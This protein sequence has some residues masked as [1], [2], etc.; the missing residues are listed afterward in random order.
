MKYRSVDVHD[1]IEN[2]QVTNMKNIAGDGSRV[3]LVQTKCDVVVF[4][5]WIG[6]NKGI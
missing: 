3:V 6:E 2:T 4:K 1:N 5:D